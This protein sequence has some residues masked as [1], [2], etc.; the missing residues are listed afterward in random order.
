MITHYVS[1]YKQST[2]FLIT[3]SDLITKVLFYA[4]QQVM[5]IFYCNN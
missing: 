2:A 4:H 1:A 5:V 3:V